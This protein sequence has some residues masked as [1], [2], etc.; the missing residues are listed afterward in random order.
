[1]DQQTTSPAPSTSG[2]TMPA[3]CGYCAKPWNWQM[4]K[5]CA[6]CGFPQHGSDQERSN[7]I[8]DRGLEK[9]N[10]TVADEQVRKARHALF[11]V[12]ALNMIPYLIAGGAVLIVTG[13]VISGIFLGLAFW[14]KHKPLPAIITALSLY[15]LLIVLAAIE[16]PTSLFSGIILKVIVISALIYALRAL[17][18][19]VTSTRK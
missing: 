8:Y 11:V 7:F 18:Q 6:L 1:M 16:N 15:G 9:G 4:D 3:H 12:A 17:K 19:P 10:K 14:T 2:A 13:L 5:F